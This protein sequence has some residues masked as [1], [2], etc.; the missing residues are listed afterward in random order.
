MGY[1]TRQDMNLLICIYTLIVQ[2]LE[3]IK[4]NMKALI[5]KIWTTQTMIFFYSNPIG[6][7]IKIN[8]TYVKKILNFNLTF[9]LKHTLN[10]TTSIYLY[11]IY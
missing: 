6:H 3:L 7:S 1:V 11:S 2:M 5:Y 8:I 4:I 10:T 9:F